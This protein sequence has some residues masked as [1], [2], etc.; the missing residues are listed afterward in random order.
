[1]VK[2]AEPPYDIYVKE[3]SI[4]NKTHEK[5]Y[6]GI[7]AEDQLEKDNKRACEIKR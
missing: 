5:A 4:L 7:G 1:L 2:D 6:I 3:K